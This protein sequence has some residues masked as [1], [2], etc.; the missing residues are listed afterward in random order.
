MNNRKPQRKI[1]VRSAVKMAIASV[2]GGVHPLDLN[3][4]DL[5][6]SP[7]SL[8]IDVGKD[9]AACTHHRY[10]CAACGQPLPVSVQRRQ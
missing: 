2:E 6:P 9:A 7:T 8:D 3:V 5:D 1:P 10:V 4:R